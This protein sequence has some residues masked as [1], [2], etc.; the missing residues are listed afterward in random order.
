MAIPLST[1]PAV[2]KQLYAIF[3]TA[4]ATVPAPAPDQ[5]GMLVQYGEP[6]PYQPDDIVS[7]GDVKRNVTPH[8]IVGTGGAGALNENYVVEYW[9]DVFRGGDQPEYVTERAYTILGAL[10]TAV[11]NDPSLGGLVQWAWPRTSEEASGWDP[12]NRGRQTQIRGE[13]EVSVL[14]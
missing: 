4:V 9:V 3:T 13:I 7:V 5:A 12:D 14:I 1:V 10:E 11:R 8:N 2:K 6:G